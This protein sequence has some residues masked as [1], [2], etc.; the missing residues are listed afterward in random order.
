MSELRLCPGFIT[1]SSTSGTRPK[2]SRIGGTSSRCWPVL[3]RVTCQSLWARSAWST[4]Q[5]LMT[6]GRVPNTI[7]MRGW[8]DG[9]AAGR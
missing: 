8:V 5:S 9:I 2:L 7:R 3:Q 1:P 6:S 4:G